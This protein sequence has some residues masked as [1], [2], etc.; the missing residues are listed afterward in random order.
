MNKGLRHITI[1]MIV[2]LY[3]NYTIAQQTE[4]RQETSSSGFIEVDGS[5]LNYVVEGK[6]KPC[7]VIGSSVYYPKTFSKNLRK[8]LKMYFVDMKWFAKEYMPENLDSVNI[9]SIVEDVEKIRKKLGLNQPM[10]MGHS[11]HGTIAVEYAKKYS[12]NVSSLVIIGSP[13]LWGSKSF[14]QKAA[15]LWETA[16]EERKA[17]QNQNWGD[18]T[19]LD[20]LTGKEEATAAYNRAA[21]QYWYDPYY[22]ASWLWDGMTVHSEVTKHLFTNVFLNYDMF[23]PSTEIPV[24]VFVGLGKYDYVIPYTLWSSYYESIPDFTLV[25]FEKSGHTPQLEETKIFD[26]KLL[27]WINKNTK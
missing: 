16:S 26:K 19:E 7:L 6:G 25:V 8:H 18:I 9:K 5:K 10:I 14:D 20:R 24:P 23:E 17:I 12:Q 4:K 11:I 27:N 15:A 21:P 2:I 3:C 22:D 13:A 1:S